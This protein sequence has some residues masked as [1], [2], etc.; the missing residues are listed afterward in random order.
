MQMIEADVIRF[1]SG[2]LGAIEAVCNIQLIVD[3]LSAC[4][5]GVS[6]FPASRSSMQPPQ[7]AVVS[8]TMSEALVA[9]VAGAG[10]GRSASDMPAVPHAFGD[11]H[12]DMLVTNAEMTSVESESESLADEM[13]HTCEN[14]P[15]CEWTYPECDAC[16]QEHT[17]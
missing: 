11:I 6:V 10:T 4:S 8:D 7:P 2:K 13:C 17:G 14:K 15:V 12:T 1:R 9:D 5:G 3:D 16:Y